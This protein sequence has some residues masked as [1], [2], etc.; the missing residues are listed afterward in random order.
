MRSADE[1]VIIASMLTAHARI[2]T[3][4][5]AESKQKRAWGSNFKDKIS[6]PI[7]EIISN[8]NAI[9]KELVDTISA[10]G[11]GN[12][13]EFV[14]AIALVRKEVYNAKNERD[15]E[16]FLTEAL[17]ALH[18]IFD[19]EFGYANE[20]NEKVNLETREGLLKMIDKAVRTIEEVRSV[21]EISEVFD[22]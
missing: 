4:L 3:Q 1:K 2:I 7:D 12:T 13:R 19:R 22:E 16:H 14:N 11:F 9:E 10:L 8:W 17:F 21:E 20:K 15:N 18:A 6:K 5:D